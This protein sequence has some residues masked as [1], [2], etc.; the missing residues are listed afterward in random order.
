MMVD[1]GVTTYNKLCG[2]TA[3]CMQTNSVFRTP[4]THFS[5]R[6]Y[7]NVFE[8]GAIIMSLQKEKK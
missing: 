2:N 1:D 3:R 4:T 6:K 8:K 7:T 5:R